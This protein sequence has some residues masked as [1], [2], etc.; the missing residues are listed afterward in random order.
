MGGKNPQ[1]L[2]E[3]HHRLKHLHINPPKGYGGCPLSAQQMGELYPFTLSYLEIPVHHR[4]VTVVKGHNT[5]QVVK[6]F[7]VFNDLVL[8][9]ELRP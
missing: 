6:F 5:S 3:E 7:H 4:P 9:P 2:P 1:R 8:C